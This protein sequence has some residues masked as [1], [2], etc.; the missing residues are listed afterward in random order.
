MN[1]KK[2]KQCKHHSTKVIWGRDE[3]CCTADPHWI[4]SVALVVQCPGFE[5][6]QSGKATKAVWQA[7]P[8]RNGLWTAGRLISEGRFQ[9]YEL[10]TDMNGMKHEWKTKEEAERFCTMMRE[11]WKWVN[12]AER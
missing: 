11:C 10:A 9:C 4:T 12:L 5:P 2:C 1:E 3:M 8:E 6:M 7:L